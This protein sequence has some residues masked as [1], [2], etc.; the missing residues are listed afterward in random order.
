MCWDMWHAWWRRWMHTRFWWVNFKETKQ[1]SLWMPFRLEPFINYFALMCGKGTVNM[2]ILKLLWLLSWGYH[3][4][5]WVINKIGFVWVYVGIHELVSLWT[6]VTTEP[7][8][9]HNSTGLRKIIFNTIIQWLTIFDCICI[10]D[11]PLLDRI[12]EELPEEVREQDEAGGSE[13]Q[14]CQSVASDVPTHFIQIKAGSEEVRY[15][16]YRSI[17]GVYHYIA[18]RVL[19]LMTCCG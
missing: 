10:A 13:K 9:T 8:S 11:T 5:H 14:E 7:V 6:E 2:N 12:K 18:G 15:L 4:K 3:H 19:S 16:C 1:N 17:I